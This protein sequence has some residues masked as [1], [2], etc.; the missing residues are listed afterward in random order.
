MK[1]FSINSFEILLITSS[2][3]CKFK[4]IHRVLCFGRL[5]DYISMA[6]SEIYET[7]TAGTFPIAAVFDRERSDK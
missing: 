1:A 4:R 2:T 5:I 6:N 7:V 3:L